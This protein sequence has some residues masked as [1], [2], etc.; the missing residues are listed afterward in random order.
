MLVCVALMATYTWEEDVDSCVLTSGLFLW[1][2]RCTCAQLLV[3]LASPSTATPADHALDACPMHHE[4]RQSV[5]WHRHSS[6]CAC[7]CRDKEPCTN[8]AYST[9]APTECKACMSVGTGSQQAQERRQQQQVDGNATGECQQLEQNASEAIGKAAQQ[10]QQ[11]LATVEESAHL[12]HQQKASEQQ[13]HEHE[14]APSHSL[15]QQQHWQQ[16]AH[17]QEEPAAVDFGP[18]FSRQP[19]RV[20]L[21]HTEDI[22]D[23]SWSAGGFILTAS[24]DKSVRLWHVSQPDCLREFWHSD[25]VTSVQ[26]HP[27]DAQRFV[28][29][30]LNNLCRV[31]A[32]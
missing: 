20:F 17:T 24:L 1:Q 10:Q 2:H 9:P 19:V 6:C 29:G 28:S 3:W 5:I 32:A 22:L 26:F 30:K 21:G 15:A 7:H 8:W 11:L 31:S 13:H 4:E 25:F 18:Y 12:A 27:L 14:K 23:I 16:Q